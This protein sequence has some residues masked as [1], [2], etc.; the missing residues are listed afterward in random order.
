MGTQCPTPAQAIVTTIAIA[1]LTPSLTPTLTPTLTVTLALDPRWARLRGESF[2]PA[3]WAADLANPPEEWLENAN[4]GVALYTPDAVMAWRDRM[5]CWRV[6]PLLPPFVDKL[7]ANKL[8]RLSVQA[9]TLGQVI[10]NL[11]SWARC[12]SAGVGTLDFLTSPL[13][14]GWAIHASQHSGFRVSVRKGHAP[15]EVPH[16]RGRLSGTA[17]RQICVHASTQQAWRKALQWVRWACSVRLPRRHRMRLAR[18]SST[19]PA[20]FFGQLGFL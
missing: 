20:R 10:A 1:S 4:G 14:K 3:L 7:P 16:L 18:R 11:V 6:S 2:V 5:R 12:F 19:P 9:P 8:S 17:T 15:S 13:V